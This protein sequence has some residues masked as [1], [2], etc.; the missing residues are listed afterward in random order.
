MHVGDTAG[1]VPFET[2]AL[3]RM[4]DFCTERLDASVWL[5]QAGCTI[6]RHRNPLGIP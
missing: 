4:V 3:D 2:A 1:I 5:K 6:L